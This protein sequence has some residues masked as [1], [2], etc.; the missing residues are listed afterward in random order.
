MQANWSLVLN[1]LLLLGVIIAIRRVIKTKRQYKDSLLNQPPLGN[2]ESKPFDDIIAVRKVSADVDEVSVEDDLPNLAIS[3]NNVSTIKKETVESISSIPVKKDISKPI[4]LFLQAK[5]NR[6]LAGY[7]LLQTLLA[8]GLRFGEGQLFHRHYK[9]N[10][11]GPIV[12]SLAAATATGVFDLQNMGDFSA[13][14]LCLFMQPSGN[15]KIDTDH[16]TLMLDT[17]KQLSDGLDALL[18][19][20]QRQPLTDISI[21]RYYNLF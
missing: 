18:L 2:V 3:P 20:Y 6:K 5:A 19:D 21:A 4:I 1:V 17:A 11:Q 14:G 16:L 12:C 7:E 10:G 15:S 13:K 8:A 9:P